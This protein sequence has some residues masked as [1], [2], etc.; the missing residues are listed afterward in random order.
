MPWRRSISGQPVVVFTTNDRPHYL[1]ETLVSWSHVRG[2]E[3]ALLIFSCEPS[4][5]MDEIVNLLKIIPFAEV[6]ISVNDRQ[7]GVEVNPYKAEYLGFTTTDAD[8]VIQA[9]DDAT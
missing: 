1:A 5:E 4:P 8:F 6:R 7:M 3:D 2:I 9:E